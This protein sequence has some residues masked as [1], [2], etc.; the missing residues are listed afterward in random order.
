MVEECLWCNF[1]QS[2]FATKYYEANAVRLYGSPQAGGCDASCAQTH[3]CAVTRIE[4]SEFRMCLEAAASALAS[5]ASMPLITSI[6]V[7]I[8]SQLFVFYMQV[9]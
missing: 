4:Y 6:P 3:F 5:P 9:T 8:I 1:V 2:T 7:V